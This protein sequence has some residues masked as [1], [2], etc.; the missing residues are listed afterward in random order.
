MLEQYIPI[1][2]AVLAGPF[3]R[4]VLYELIRDG[5]VIAVKNGKRTLVQVA[6]LQRAIERRR[7]EPQG[8]AAA[9]AV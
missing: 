4:S 2:Q 8:A 3:G 9:Q 1:Q 6:S 5:E 7:V